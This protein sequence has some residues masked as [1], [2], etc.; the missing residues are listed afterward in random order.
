MAVKTKETVEE[1]ESPLEILEPEIKEKII[2]LGTGDDELI[3]T[4]KPLS[5]FG[6][7]EFFS[8]MGKAI[9][10]VLSEGG[11]I[12]EIFDS[13]DD[14]LSSSTKE[15]DLF[16]KSIAKVVQY[17]PE[18]L[19]DIYCV[20]LAVPRGDRDYVKTRLVDELTD[21]L[22]F[23]ILDTFVDQNWEILTSFFT[24][25]GLPLFK[26]ITKKLQK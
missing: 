16:I 18:T 13:P 22:G 5:F 23:D 3:F 17:A 12:S 24:E 9:E 10:R 19:L 4:Q 20:V 8:V 15:A 14:I 21:E 2:T 1:V 6:K 7:I 26:K 11:S 25:K